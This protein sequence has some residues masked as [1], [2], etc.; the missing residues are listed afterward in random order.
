MESPIYILETALRY[1]ISCCGMASIYNAMKS[2]GSRAVQQIISAGVNSV[3]LA[4]LRYSQIMKISKYNCHYSVSLRKRKSVRWYYQ[5]LE[6]A[7][8]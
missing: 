3:G 2:I 6:A 7:G 5:L 1:E 4:I 8:R